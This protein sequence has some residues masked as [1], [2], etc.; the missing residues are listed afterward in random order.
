MLYEV[1]IRMSIR[2]WKITASNTVRA[3]DACR[4]APGVYCEQ[5][6][7][8][9]GK[10][11]TIDPRFMSGTATLIQD[12]KNLALD[13][14]PLQA[15]SDVVD[16]W[17]HQ[18]DTDQIPDQGRLSA[19]FDAALA[20]V[21][22]IENG[23]LRQAVKQRPIQGARSITPV[24]SNGR[25]HTNNVAATSEVLN[26]SPPPEPDFIPT[27]RQKAMLEALE[28]RALR[29]DAWAESSKVEKSG[30]MRAKKELQARGLVKHHKGLGFYR[31]D[32]PPPGLVATK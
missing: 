7:G 1:L 17:N 19:M 16:S 28:G 11:K 20:T 24:T 8:R 32:A 27:G 3:L 5:C 9:N 2:Q 14:Q 23:L 31:P 12:A 21:L 22:A 4:Q 29:S 26:V 30:L 10:R 15:F 13:P 6:A 25:M 18:H